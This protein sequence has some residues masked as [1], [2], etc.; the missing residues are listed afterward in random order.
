MSWSINLIGKP[1]NVVKALEEQS[2][3]LSGQSKVE[4]DDALVHFVGLVKQNFAQ[5]PPMINFQASGHGMENGEQSY[6]QCKVNIDIL[7]GTFV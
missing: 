3:K 5:T 2:E 7:Y 6:R 1:E 4:F